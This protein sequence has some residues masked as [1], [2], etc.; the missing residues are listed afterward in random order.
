[1]APRA[2]PT[3]HATTTDHSA[4][5]GR[6]R[7]R[8]RRRGARRPAPDHDGG[9]DAR[10]VPGCAG[11]PRDRRRSGRRDERASRRA[12]HRLALGAA[13]SADRLRD[14]DDLLDKRGDDLG[15][16]RIPLE[17]RRHRTSAAGRPMSSGARGTRSTRSRSAGTRPLRRTRATRRRGLYYSFS[18]D[19]GTSWNTY[20]ARAEQPEPREHGTVDHVQPVD[21]AHL[22]RRTRSRTAAAAPRSSASSTTAADGTGDQPIGNVS[23]VPAPPNA[24]YEHPSIAALPNG[25]VAIAYY[26]AA[27]PAGAR[28][29]LLAVGRPGV[30][31]RAAPRRR[32]RST[33]RRPSRP[34]VCSAGSP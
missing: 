21:R 22:R 17:L 24:Q 31:R 13:R 27:N 29:D 20:H 3:R 11:R 8:G 33:A 18:L 14:R 12:R 10:R 30:P 15:R 25:K 16:S 4:P 32:S 23:P 9:Q 19:G 2:R 34:R 26:D 6:R 28:H 5:P 7:A 1:M